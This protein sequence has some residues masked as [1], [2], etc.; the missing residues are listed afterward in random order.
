MLQMGAGRFR[1]FAALS[2]AL[3]IAGCGGSAATPSGHI[4]VIATTTLLASLAA[5]VGGGR[6]DVASLLPVGTSPETYQ[7][8]PSDVARLHDARVIIENGAGLESWLEPTL[9]NVRGTDVRVVTCADG[10]PVVDGNP[11]LWLNPVY[12]RAY[13]ARMRDAFVAADPNGA[14]TYRTNAALL[15]ARLAALD[16]GIARSLRVLPPNRRAMLVYHNAWLYYNRRYGL[17]TLGVVEENPGTE[18]SAAH[19]ARLVDLARAARLHTLFA[20]PEYS[21]KLLDAVARSAGIANVAI[22]YD[23]SV[24]TSPATRDYPS[25]LATDTRTIVAGLR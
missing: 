12:A 24:G 11:H 20:E 1:W 9:K 3:S 19:L 22:L 8:T 25:M 14:K 15:D 13:V 23:D 10:L 6:V 21:P 2:F 5:G 7:P 4:R 16:A 17:Q 18:P